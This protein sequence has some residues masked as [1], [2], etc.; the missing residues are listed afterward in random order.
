MKRIAR[1]L[2]LLSAISYPLALAAQQQPGGDPEPD[3]CSG[4]GQLCSVEWECL[5]WVF[6]NL[7]W[8]CLNSTESHTYYHLQT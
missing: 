5:L 4:Q 2:F 6:T 8:V 3:P 7:G 1:T